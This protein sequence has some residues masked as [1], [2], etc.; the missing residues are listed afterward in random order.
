[1]KFSPK[2]KLAMKD[3]KAIL[4]KHDFAGLVVLHTVGHAEYLLKIDPSY[5]IAKIDALNQEVRFKASLKDFGGDKKLM[6]SRL[7][8]TSNMLNAISTN[9]GELVLCLMQVSQQ[10]DKTV[11]A[12]HDKGMHT[13]QTEIDN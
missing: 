7:A 4:E 10:F 3:S 5:S 8:A 13:S 11:G 2:L 6:D 9:G 12:E 1:M